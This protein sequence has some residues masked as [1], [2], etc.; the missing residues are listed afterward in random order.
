MLPPS[1]YTPEGISPQGEEKI[2]KQEKFLVG[3][4]MEVFSK[5]FKGIDKSP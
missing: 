5:D 4:V 2:I 1:A 3:N